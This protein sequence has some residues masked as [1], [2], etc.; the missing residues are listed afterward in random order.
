MTQPSPL[1]RTL[2][3][4]ELLKK[5]LQV[6]QAKISRLNSEN[7]A[8]R[9]KAHPSKHPRQRLDTIRVVLFCI[10]G[11]HRLTF[12]SPNIQRYTN[13]GPKQISGQSLL[14]FI[15]P[16]DISKFIC[17]CRFITKEPSGA[18]VVRFGVASG[19]YTWVKISM[20]PLMDGSTCTGIQGMFFEISK[21]IPIKKPSTV[22][23][24]KYRKI[25]E[26]LREGFFEADT[27]G[28]ITFCNKAMLKITGSSLKD[29]V[30]SY[31][32][33]AA[34]PR[35]SRA[36]R[37]MLTRMYKTRQN[38]ILFNL[39][40]HKKSGQSVII[41]F[42]VHLIYN[43]R[44]V[45]VGF[46]GLLRDVSDRVHAKKK[47]ERILAQTNHSRK[48]NALE[49]L[50]GGV[51][52]GFNNLLMTI[53]GNLSLIRMRLSEDHPVNNHLE[54]IN[55]A[56]E[57]G[58]HLA[59]EILS[60]AKIGKFVVIPTNL[61]KIIRST[62]RM[63]TRAHANL[64]IHERL[65]E[66]LWKTRVDRVQIG[67]ALLSFYTNALDAMP[68]GGDLYL[69]SE[70]A[71]LDRSDTMPFEVEP[72]PY[73]K[74]SVIDSG[75]G[76]EDEA[77]D[78]I[79]EPFF[80]AYRR[81]EYNGLGLAAAYGTIRSHQG[82]IKVYS[83]HGHGATF[84][85]YLPAEPSD[86]KNKAPDMDKAKGRETILLVDDD[87]LCAQTCREILERL[88]Y[89]VLVAGSGSEAIER[90]RHHHGQIDLVLLDVIL[91]DI[92]GD[93]VFQAL[94]QWNPNTTVMVIS[95]YRVD[96][97]VSA[98]LAQGCVDFVQKPFSNQTLAN[99]VR[100]ALDRKAV[101]PAIAQLIS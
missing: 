12:A 68:Q 95:G 7:A 69:R 49:T 85:L 28:C 67:Q 62:Y 81:S 32:H 91:P 42:S 19:N 72:G 75:L 94:K 21:T 100:V 59:R 10:N 64:N 33:F 44:S 16:D 47:H 55:Q 58:G 77:K 50:A 76:L 20:A 52:H 79:F 29:L 92:S 36:V 56:T 30:G 39:K 14:D 84:T 23:D 13:L 4:I 65:S 1:S 51:A 80:S 15:H 60:F 46:Q 43:T 61:N 2:T 35:A 86:E 74:I 48:M 38:S 41:E 73:V 96:Q 82:F 5:K 27:T 53:Q 101:P 57:K 63:F 40:I 70:N 78:R 31:F 93:Q 26:N 11:D 3:Q 87:D 54:R 71:T 89:Q 9:Q 45:P 24:D 18:I 99:K 25:L 37:V 22:I 97:Q 6:Q 34:S 8:L 88:S 83:K 66:N 17:H 90:Y 98:L